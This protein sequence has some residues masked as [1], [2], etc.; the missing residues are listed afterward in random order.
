MTFYSQ[1]G[2]TALHL[3]SQ[4][5]HVYVAR[6]LIEANAHM[7][8][9]T[10]VLQPI[11]V[12][13]SHTSSVSLPLFLC[14][15]SFFPLTHPLN[16]SLTQPASLPPFPPPSFISPLPYLIGL[17]SSIP[18]SLLSPSLLTTSLFTHSFMFLPPSLSLSSLLPLSPPPSDGLLFLPSLPPYHTIYS[19]HPTSFSFSFHVTV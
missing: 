10:K 2:C 19:Q 17:L 4:N 7:N 15:S 14:L 3:A 12:E 8:P 13:C 5:G 6:M 16:F 18:P 9:Q 11:H 1:N